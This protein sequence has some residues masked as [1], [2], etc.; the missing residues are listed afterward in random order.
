M[1]SQERKNK[2]YKT[3]D[4][5]KNLIVSAINHSKDRMNYEYNR[6]NQNNTFRLNMILIGTLGELVFKKYLEGNN[7]AYEMEFQAGKFDSF[8][9][10]INN[11]I[12][13]IKTSGYDK[14]GLNT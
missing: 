1:N 6:F 12:I 13:E 4:I 10:I 5:D 3:I 11:K 2:I 9:F 14:D 7:Q 8:D